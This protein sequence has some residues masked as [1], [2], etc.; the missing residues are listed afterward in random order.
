MTSACDASW[1]GDGW[2]RRCEARRNTLCRHCS[3]E[4]CGPYYGQAHHGGKFSFPCAVGE[5]ALLDART[6]DFELRVV[7]RLRRVSARNMRRVVGDRDAVRRICIERER[8]F[9]ERGGRRLRREWLRRWRRRHGV[10]D[11]V[12]GE[13]GRI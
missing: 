10:K 12:E 9:G 13:G 11:V 3:G 2:R 8:V 1:A 4:D 5:G 7:E 6:H